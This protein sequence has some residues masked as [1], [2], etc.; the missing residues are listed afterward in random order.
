MY[1]LCD[2]ITL[3]AE[4]LPVGA[5][6]GIVVAAVVLSV[7][8]VS[9]ALRF[10]RKSVPCLLPPHLPHILF[11][12]FYFVSHSYFSLAIHW[13]LHIREIRPVCV[14]VLVLAVVSLCGDQ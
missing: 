9:L 4:G 14:C 8:V 5:I 11:Y 7:V 3:C 10:R 1:H 6:V 12:L 13:F 2:V